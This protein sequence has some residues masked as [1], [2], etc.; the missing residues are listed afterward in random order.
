MDVEST[1]LTQALVLQYGCHHLMVS[2]A[3]PRSETWDKSQLSVYHSFF[4]LQM[5]Y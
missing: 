3:V 2:H 1:E 5:V 4:F